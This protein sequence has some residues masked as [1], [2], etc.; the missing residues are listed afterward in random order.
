[1]VKK[2]LEKVFFLIELVKKTSFILMNIGGN[3]KNS[4]K[5]CCA[6]FHENVSHGPLK[7][8]YSQGLGFFSS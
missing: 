5:F 6:Y 3:H 4:R 8:E 7:E 1:M 2:A